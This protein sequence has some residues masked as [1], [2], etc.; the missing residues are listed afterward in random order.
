MKKK[1]GS[2]KFPDRDF[3]NRKEK[4]PIKEIIICK[5]CNCEID[6]SHSI[7]FWDTGARRCFLCSVIYRNK[8][9]VNTR[10]NVTL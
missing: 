5:D 1:K 8:C 2:L 3:L 6:I 7:F 9:V 10:K 4:L